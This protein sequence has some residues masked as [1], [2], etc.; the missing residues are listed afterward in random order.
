M[1]FEPLSH[2]TVPRQMSVVRQVVPGLWADNRESP[3]GNG[4]L[5]RPDGGAS[6]TERSA[7][8]QVSDI[9]ER[10]KFMQDLSI[11]CWHLYI[12]S[13]LLMVV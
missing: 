2:W 8:R 9:V 11:F 13:V 1:S 4:C 3:V 10:C 6:R 7:A 5:A 12:N